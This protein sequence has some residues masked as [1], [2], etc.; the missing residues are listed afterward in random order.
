MIMQGLYFKTPQIARFVCFD[1]ICPHS[2]GLI[3]E[4]EIL[5]VTQRAT[6]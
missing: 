6:L 3:I 4:R 2:N 1:M 5:T